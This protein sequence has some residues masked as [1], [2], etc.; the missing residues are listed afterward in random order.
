MVDRHA[1]YGTCTEQ[2]NKSHN[3]CKMC[4]SMRRLSRT[5]HR[6]VVPVHTTSTPPGDLEEGEPR[7]IISSKSEKIR[8]ELYHILQKYTYKEIVKQWRTLIQWS[9][10]VWWSI[11]MWL[12]WAWMKR[13]EEEEEE[14]E[15]VESGQWESNTARSW[16]KKLSQKLENCCVNQNKQIFSNWQDNVNSNSMGKRLLETVTDPLKK[17]AIKVKDWWKVKSK[18]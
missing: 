16:T 9:P 14:E 3:V 4:G 13:E 5:S 15:A 7:T 18:K 17:L 8:V 1:I 10:R 2:H 12:I 6:Q 11:N